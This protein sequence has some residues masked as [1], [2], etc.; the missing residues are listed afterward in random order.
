[1]QG[2]FRCHNLSDAGHDGVQIPTFPVSLI[3]F[4]A[5]PVDGKNQGINARSHHLLGVFIPGKT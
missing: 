2:L 4:L 5:N 3:G 1:M